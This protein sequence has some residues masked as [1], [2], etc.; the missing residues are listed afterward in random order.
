[1]DD[2]VKAFGQREASQLVALLPEVQLRGDNGAVTSR[3][4]DKYMK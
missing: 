1:M 4:G 3:H 2:A